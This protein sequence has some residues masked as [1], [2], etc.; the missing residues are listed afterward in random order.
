L[1]RGDDGPGV[2]WLQQSLTYLG[3]FGEPPTGAFEASTEAGVRA[4]QA[5]EALPIDG[6]VG[7]LTKIRLYERLPGYAPPPSIAA[8]PSS[9]PATPRGGT[10]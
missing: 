4:F 2:L 10:S 5:A 9:E 1:R 6:K 7:P 8:L 3:F